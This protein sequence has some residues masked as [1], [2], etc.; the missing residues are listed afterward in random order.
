MTIWQKNYRPNLNN[1]S[2]KIDEK[3]F[4]IKKLTTFAKKNNRF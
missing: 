4:I 2:L 1:N 3:I